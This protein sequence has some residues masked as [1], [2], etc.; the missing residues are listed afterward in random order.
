MSQRACG[1]EVQSSFANW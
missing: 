1:T